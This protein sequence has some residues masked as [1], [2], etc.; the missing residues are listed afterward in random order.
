MNLFAAWFWYVA[1]AV[2]EIAGCYTLWMWL[3]LD[4]SALWLLPGIIALFLFA[5]ILTRVDLSLAGRTYAAYGG[6]YIIASLVWVVIV[7]QSRPLPSDILGAA[8]ILLGSAV[9]LMGGRLSGS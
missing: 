3:R 9:I 1:A 7:E 4:R 6:I 2:F 8:I 5:A